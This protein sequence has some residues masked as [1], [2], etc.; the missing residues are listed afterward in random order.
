[1]IKW[2]YSQ[3]W[4]HWL[5]NEFYQTYDKVI[6]VYGWR[7]AL[8]EAKSGARKVTSPCFKILGIDFD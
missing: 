3:V 1:M 4:K 8:V 2:L 5:W 7:T 6:K